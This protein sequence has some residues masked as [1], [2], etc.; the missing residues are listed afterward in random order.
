MKLLANCFLLVITSLCL[1]DENYFQHEIQSG[2]KPWTD[3]PIV[4]SEAEFHF[5]VVSDRTTGGRKGI[6]EDA[7][8]KI[9]LLQPAFVV[10]IGDSVEGYTTNRQQMLK[11]W[12]EFNSIVNQLNMRFFYVPGNHDT[13]N[14]E[15]LA[16][17]Q[18]LYGEKYYY[19]IYKNMLFIILHSQESNDCIGQTQSDW[20]V[21][22]LKKYPNAKETFVFVHYPIWQDEYL[23][24]YKELA[25]LFSELCQRNH[26]IFAGHIHSYMKFDRNKQKY[27]RL[28]TTGGTM[29]GELGC[30]DHF[31]WVSVFNDRRP[32]FANVMLD[33]IADENIFME[34]M[35]KEI[36]K[37]QQS[38]RVDR[39]NIDYE[40]KSFELPLVI[41]N[42]YPNAAMKYRI[43]L[44][45]NKNWSFS[46][47]EF[48]GEIPENQ[49]I[50]LPI[51]GNVK[52]VFPLPQATGEFKIHGNNNINLK[53]Q[54][55]FFLVNNAEISIPY[56]DTPPVIDG[57]LEDKCWQKPIDEKFRE[58]NSFAASKVETKVWLAYDNNYLYWAAKCYEPDK[59]KMIMSH[60]K[61]DFEFNEED[62]DD[63]LELFL[64]TGCDRELYY[65][66]IITAE[67]IIKDSC[68]LDKKFNAAVKSSVNLDADGWT[69]EMA[70]PWKDLKV[71]SPEGKKMGVLL[72]RT[73]HGRENRC[74]L[75]AVTGYRKAENFGTLRLI[76]PSDSASNK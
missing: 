63:N 10:T 73:R 64:D 65:H 42:P 62:L 27:F 36:A 8:K 11:E 26:T 55:P 72:S 37:I 1:A 19:F 6:F 54:I 16:M 45:G 14:P 23:K 59:S 68:V 3:K 75:P 30:F 39:Q 2:V 40:D 70:I 61:R 76:P 4:D 25:P 43:N 58:F 66:F 31:M 50:V 44:T 67:N 15:M 48:K 9:N 46:I 41:K 22:V 5:A 33:G 52:T 28:A 7:V 24:Q 53:L 34:E 57:R 47:P 32:I 17:W 60:P 56:T 21:N 49:E 13:S 35:A 38:I 12:R 74:D 71:I 69:M 18:K 51:K 20:A 29:L